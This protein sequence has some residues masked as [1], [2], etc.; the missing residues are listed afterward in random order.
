[1]A[2]FVLC[3]IPWIF[4][5]QLFLACVIPT[6]QYSGKSNEVSFDDDLK[7]DVVLLDRKIARGERAES[8][9]FYQNKI[10]R[11]PEVLRWQVLYA[12]TVENDEEAERL[13]S[14]LVKKDPN[15]YYAYIGLGRI[16]ER[17]GTRERAE[18]AYQAA[19]KLNPRLED[20]PL[21]MARVYREQQRL[22]Q[23]AALY[24]QILEEHPRSYRA[25]YGQ[26]QL[27]LMQN[28]L[29]KAREAFV[30]ATQWYKEYYDGWLAMAT[31]DERQGRLQD[32]K[33]GLLRAIELRPQ[34][35]EPVLLLARV[36]ERLGL[37]AEAKLAYDRLSALMGTTGVKKDNSLTKE[38]ATSR[39]KEAISREDWEAALSS[40]K[41]AQEVD[42]QD[43]SLYRIE[44]EI[45]LGRESYAKALLAYETALLT[46]PKDEAARAGR[47]SVVTRL[48]AKEGPFT[49]KTENDVLAS[50]QGMV[51]GCYNTTKRQFPS[52][53]G[54]V[55]LKVQALSDGSVGQ[56]TFSED[57]LKSPEVSA[58]IEW[59][60]RQAAFPIG[61][62]RNISTSWDFK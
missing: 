45:H 38:I 60:L 22:E 42:P 49:G 28:D 35:S 2:K 37:T 40:I 27:A 48:G 32:A 16:Y 11:E 58:C 7:D 29:L 33:A 6:P 31:L 4:A 10:T 1:M 53:A 25:V 23:S 56:I 3:S 43:A 62:N 17:W 57:T 12:M 5:A 54:K 51:S 19:T 34:A 8:L 21:G 59:G 47:A 39:A 46:N 50:V 14:A 44:A 26:G 41:E 30:K 55:T 9:K 15:I 24:Q 13:L 61:T 18:A 20:A 36:N 52:L